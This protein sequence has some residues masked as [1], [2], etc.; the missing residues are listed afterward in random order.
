MRDIKCKYGQIIN[1]DCLEVMKT[2]EENSIDL[3]LTDV[4][5]GVNFKND[6]YD[7]SK[8]YV[9]S[10]YEEWIR[11]YSR[12]LK[13]GSHCYIFIPTLEADKWISMVKKYLNFNNLLATRTYTKN[14]YLKNNFKY[15][16]Q[17]VIFASK[18]TAN[19][20]NA[21]DFIKTSESWFKDKRNSNP[22]EFTYMYPSFM[23]DYIFSNV[24]GNSKEA[25]GHPNQKNVSFLKNLI[26]LSSN[27][28]DIVLDSFMGS[29]S[30]GLACVETN[31]KFICIEQ[32]E[33]YYGIGINRIN[34]FNKDILST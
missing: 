3:I 23:P 21:V 34:E 11:E 28:G 12:L 31:R 16:L 22:K 7:D 25:L 24:K 1:G 13:N 17:L 9:F 32:D 19:R 33:K 20:L 14:L 4:P 2:L 10:N 29:N 27:E 6:F 5:Y 26:M 18:G 8:D 30:T 15:D